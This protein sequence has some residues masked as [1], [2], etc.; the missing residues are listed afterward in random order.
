ML[1]IVCG[2][3]V[4]LIYQKRAVRSSYDGMQISDVSFVKLYNYRYRFEVLLLCTIVKV[5][6]TRFLAGL[7][8]I[9]LT[10]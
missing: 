4:Q 3:K 1:Y 7:T 6:Q 10:P 9:A 8:K 2:I 5:L